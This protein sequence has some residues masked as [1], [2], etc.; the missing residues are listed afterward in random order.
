[1][2]DC[3][4]DYI[5]FLKTNQEIS[6]Y[7]N[8]ISRAVVLKM[9]FLSEQNSA[10]NCGAYLTLGLPYSMFLFY[11]RRKYHIIAIMESIQISCFSL[12][13]GRLKFVHLHV[14]FNLNFRANVKRIIKF[15]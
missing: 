1:M 6:D 14:G 11:T 2:N 8:G 3:S 7:L 13:S 4:R 15:F 12:T 10:T 5:L 9:L